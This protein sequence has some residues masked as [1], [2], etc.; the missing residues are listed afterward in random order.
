MIIT[1]IKILKDRVLQNQKTAGAAARRRQQQRQ[2]QLGGSSTCGSLAAAR[3]QGRHNNNI[4]QKYSGIGYYKITRLRGSS[5]M[6]AAAA[7]WQQQQ[8]L[9]DSTASGATQ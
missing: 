6:A 2:R 7:A 3:C 9:G 1:S 8:Q 5:A 4:N